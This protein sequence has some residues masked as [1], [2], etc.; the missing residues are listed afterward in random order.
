MTTNE[1]ANWQ[2][3]SYLKNA[4]GEFSNPFDRGCQQNCIDACWPQSAPATPIIF[5]DE[6]MSL[7]RMEQGQ[8]SN[9]E[10]RGV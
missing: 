9:N 4:E 2:R 10:T 1:L 8:L 6:K 3:Y 5:S 7:L